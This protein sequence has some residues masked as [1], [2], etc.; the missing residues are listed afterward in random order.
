MFYLEEGE[1][2]D[3]AQVVLRMF[4]SINEI[5]KMIII[6]AQQVLSAR[7][8]SRRDFLHRSRSLARD[9]TS[10]FKVLKT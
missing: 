9:T 2:I 1:G 3:P 8:W 4:E 10:C 5:K 6:E 7:L